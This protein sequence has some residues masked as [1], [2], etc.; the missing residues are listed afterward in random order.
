MEALQTVQTS[1]A[2]SASDIRESIIEKSTDLR[3]TILEKGTDIRETI[4]E[5]G[6]DIRETLLEKGTDIRESIIE[7]RKSIAD[8]T[9][10][11]Q[12]LAGEK[13]ASCL[14]SA[15][16]VRDTVSDQAHNY[17]RIAEETV[18]DGANTFKKY[19]ET[20]EYPD[21]VLKYAEKS[22]DFVK[23][24]STEYAKDVSDAVSEL[25]N[26]TGRF[27]DDRLKEA[28]YDE[29]SESKYEVSRALIL[30]TYAWIISHLTAYYISLGNHLNALKSD[31]SLQ[32]HAEGSIWFY[33]NMVPLIVYAAYD[34]LMNYIPIDR[35]RFEQRL[36][37]MKG[38]T[39]ATGTVVVEGI[40]QRTHEPLKLV[41]DRCEPIKDV[42]KDKS[43]S[44]EALVKNS[45][46]STMVEKGI[47]S[48][49]TLH[50]GKGDERSTETSDTTDASPAA[51]VGK[52][53]AMVIGDVQLTA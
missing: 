31:N 11:V 46:I 45:G 24:Q 20:I 27:I 34:R 28:D 52:K 29:T 47:S 21:S 49:K 23:R 39:I 25:R 32:K 8:T 7:K 6:T 40:V 44:I 37:E 5:K 14:D 36:V 12:K 3:E 2:T 53:A 22:G 35:H 51:D 50:S 38:N 18:T 16:E 42:F 43:A 4:L 13:V 30:S 17:Y 10:E 9:S 19:A 48:L 1:L 33:L 26:R 15:K 41:A